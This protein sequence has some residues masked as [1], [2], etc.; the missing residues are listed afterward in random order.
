M[1]ACNILK[2]A[3]KK[4]Y[5]TYYITLADAVSTLMSSDAYS[6]RAKIK[7]VDFLVLDEVDQRFFPT[8]GSRELYG[9]HFENIFRTRVQNLLPTIICTNSLIVD[10]IFEG[11]FRYSFESLIS[12]HAQ[13]IV[14]GGKDVRKTK[15]KLGE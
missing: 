12:Q 14:V 6:F 3:I 7:Y 1:G 8:E 5:S 15:E 2:S 13:I 9:N 4:K 10:E 11:E